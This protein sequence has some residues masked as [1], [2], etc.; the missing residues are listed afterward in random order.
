MQT[1]TRWCSLIRTGDDDSVNVSLAN[2]STRLL[3][4]AL[5][6]PHF[7]RPVLLFSRCFWFAFLSFNIMKKRAELYVSHCVLQGASW[8]ILWGVDMRQHRHHSP[9]SMKQT[10]KKLAQQ[11][12]DYFFG[13]V[14]LLDLPTE[15][16]SSISVCVHVFFIF[17]FWNRAAVSAIPR[18]KR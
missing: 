12:V 13:L 9:L 8:L 6:I 10:K 15:L 14:A 1:V 3:F 5:Q 2:S 11:P 4:S 17:I 18:A 7:P 16:H